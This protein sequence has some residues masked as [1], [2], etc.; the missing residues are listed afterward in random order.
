[1]SI[2][3]YYNGIT[4]NMIVILEYICQDDNKT[5]YCTVYIPWPSHMIVTTQIIIANSVSFFMTAHDHL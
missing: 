2:L 5:V 4:I 3:P 1:V